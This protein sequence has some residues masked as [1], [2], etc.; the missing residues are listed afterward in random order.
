[1]ENKNKK[2]IPTQ[3]SK[4]ISDMKQVQ[5]NIEMVEDNMSKTVESALLK[6]VENSVSSH[7][8]KNAENGTSQSA[9]LLLETKYRRLLVVDSLGKLVG[10]I[11]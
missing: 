2:N 4:N 9:R 11:T 6:N 1:M 7:I 10:I 5:T 8:V 3:E